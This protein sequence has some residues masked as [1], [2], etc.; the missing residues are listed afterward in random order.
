[1]KYE[2]GTWVSQE[3][4]STKREDVVSPKGVKVPKKLLKGGED[5]RTGLKRR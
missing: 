2:R 1:M 4:V 5:L 3:E